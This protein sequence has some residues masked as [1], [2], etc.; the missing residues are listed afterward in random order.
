MTLNYDTSGVG[1]NGVA[2]TH[3]LPTALT[4][5]SRHYGQA[6]PGYSVPG[7]PW[8][9]PYLVQTAPP[10]MQQVDVSFCTHFFVG[11]PFLFLFV[12]NLFIT[13][14]KEYSSSYCSS[15]AIKFHIFINNY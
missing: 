14:L 4:Q 1:Q 10:H 9:T 15:N 12:L 11:F 8:V 7:T 2:T 6:L 3:M 5:Y 13:Y